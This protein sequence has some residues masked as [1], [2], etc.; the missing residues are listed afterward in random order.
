MSASGCFG[1]EAHEHP[2]EDAGAE[3]VA[4]AGSADEPGA[5]APCQVLDP[6]SPALDPLSEFLPV[7]LAAVRMHLFTAAL[8]QGRIALPEPLDLLPVIREYMLRLLRVG[9]HDLIEVRS[10]RRPAPASAGSAPRAQ[11]ALRAAG[12]GTRK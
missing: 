3:D 11:G 4:G 1:H 12:P 7:F 6:A 2:V 9:D 5:D 8:E 10:R